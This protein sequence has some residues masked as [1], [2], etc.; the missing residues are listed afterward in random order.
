MSPEEFEQLNLEPDKKDYLRRFY[1]NLSNNVI[2]EIASTTKNTSEIGNE[3]RQLI[4][5]LT[6]LNLSL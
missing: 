2:R 4:T 6:M 1:S 5:A 3:L